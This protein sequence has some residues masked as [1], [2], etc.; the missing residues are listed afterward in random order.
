MTGGD[1]TTR[2]PLTRLIQVSFILVSYSHAPHA[3]PGRDDV[4]GLRSGRAETVRQRQVQLF[5]LVR[6][7]LLPA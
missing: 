7:R 2:K 5:H 6:N 4:D 1:S 3:Q